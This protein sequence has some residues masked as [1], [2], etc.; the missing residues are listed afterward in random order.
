MNFVSL[1]VTLKDTPDTGR[2]RGALLILSAKIPAP[3]AHGRFPD[4]KKE[5]FRKLPLVALSVAA[6]VLADQGSNH[7]RNGRRERNDGASEKYWETWR[8]IEAYFNK[9]SYR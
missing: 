8:Q 2:D 6:G 5:V 3:D 1:H 9:R 4:D 7:T